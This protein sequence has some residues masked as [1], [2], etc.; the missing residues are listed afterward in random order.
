MSCPSLGSLRHQ[1]LRAIKLFLLAKTMVG[2]WKVRRPKS[3]LPVITK[4]S[5]KCSQATFSR[6]RQL[7]FWEFLG[8]LPS[9]VQRFICPR[10]KLKEPPSRQ[11]LNEL[12]LTE[13]FNQQTEKP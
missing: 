6:V 8:S 12:L 2:E 11:L 4:D 3:V 10:H 13:F 5:T 1:Y 7:T 9:R